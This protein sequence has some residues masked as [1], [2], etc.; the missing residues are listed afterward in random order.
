MRLLS[1][2]G[3][4]HRSRQ[5][6][7][8]TRA[9]DRQPPGPIAAAAAEA[10][11]AAK[12]GVDLAVELAALDFRAPAAP[13]VTIVVPVHNQLHHTVQCL[14][15]LARLKPERSFEL[16]LAD[17]ASTDA[18]G[19]LLPLVPGLK[20]RRN[21]SNLGFLETCNAAAESAG[22][23]YLVLLNNDTVV[24]P[25]WLD[26]LV[27]TFDEHPGAGLA[28]SMLL[29]PGGRLQEAGALVANNGAGWNVGRDG[30]PDH[31]RFNHVRAVDYCSGA[32]VAIP[33]A[34]WH[35]LGGFDVRFAPGYYEDTDLAFRVR[36][37][38][39]EV[40][41]QPFSRAVHFEG[42]TAG[43][44]PAAGMKR[45]MLANKPRFAAKWRAALAAHPTEERLGTAPIGRA[46][47]GRALWIDTVTLTPEADAGSLYSSEFIRILRRQG[48]CVDFVP[49]EHFDHLGETTAAMQRAGIGCVYRPYEVSARDFVAA[50][51]RDYELVVL[52]RVPAAS[53]MYDLVRRSAPRARI[54]FNTI[55][56]YHLRA[57]RQAAVTRDPAAAADAKRWR[58][59]ELRLVRAADATIVVS[60]AEAEVLRREGVR[61]P[62]HAIPLIQPVCRVNGG[63][64][65]RANLCF[66]GGF[67]HPPNS[68]A[69]RSFCAAIWPI[70]AEA[71]PEARFLIVGS[72]APPALDAPR[73][74]RI[75]GCGFVPDLATVFDH[76]RLS[77]APLR[78]GAGMKGKVVASLAH[79]VPV[80]TTTIGAEGIGLRHRHDAMI[81]DSPREF[82]DAVIE[83]YSHEPLWQT[84]SAN[85]LALV[86]KQFSRAAA[87]PRIA[88]VTAR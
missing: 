16:V 42:V 29:W 57:A 22:G 49:A 62:V 5:P 4:L 10:L 61:R 72:G 44:T 27:G 84:L 73:S 12:P 15:S 66:L 81:A 59:A 76:V 32:S 83:V 63:F 64:G 60:S 80:V 45:A 47:K 74:E 7:G 53:A 3:W 8:S 85:G 43:R 58:K 55:D 78:F 69:V 23:K 36:A 20:Y 71:V 14:K 9:P 79:G 34:L 18:T 70:I 31:W 1:R 19:T 46:T 86:E 6:T 33:R 38:G 30:D 25:G 77:V 37:A 87:E 88:A 50:H 24:L 52:A 2:M 21:P 41:Y 54:V 51:A 75:E 35:E 82:A 39:A 17:D 48:W 56:L 40:L 28:G 68:D 65:D 26:A 13:D 67:N 11:A